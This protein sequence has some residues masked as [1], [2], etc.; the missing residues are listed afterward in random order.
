MRYV[1]LD[2]G[3][4]SAD[5]GAAGQRGMMIAEFEN[6]QSAVAFVLY[7]LAQGDRE[8]VAVDTVTGRVVFPRAGTEYD[9]SPP[10]ASGTR[11]RVLVAE[12]EAQS[13]QAAFRRRGR[14]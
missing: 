1:V 7:R 11:R 10:V 8:I 14:R 9:E 4:G 3:G 2:I 12:S 6:E 13:S 5:P